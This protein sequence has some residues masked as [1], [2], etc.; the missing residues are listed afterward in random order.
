MKEYKRD[1]EENFDLMLAYKL[2]IDTLVEVRRALIVVVV[3]V[4]VVVGVKVVLT[5]VLRP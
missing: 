4:V 5:V 1:T 2:E 3:V